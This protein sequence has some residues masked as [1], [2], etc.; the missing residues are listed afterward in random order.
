VDSQLQTVCFVDELINIRDN[1]SSLSN[2]VVF[3][4]A[5]FMDII[6]YGLHL[7]SLTVFL[8]ENSLSALLITLRKSTF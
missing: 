3:T 5:E 6:H 8:F 7:I 4:G 1:I 2:Y